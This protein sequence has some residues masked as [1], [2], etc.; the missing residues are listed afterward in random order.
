MMSKKDL[1][2]DT[3]MTFGEHLEVLRV[4]LWKAIVGLVIGTAL[5]FFVSRP[6]IIAIQV[7]VIKALDHHFGPGA[8]SKGAIEKGFIESAVDWY[9]SVTKKSLDDVKSEENA[10]EHGIADPRMKFSLNVRELAQ[11]LHEFSPKEYPAPAEDAHGATIEISIAHSPLAEYL[12]ENQRQ[13][14]NP[15]TDGVDEAFMVY[16]KVSMVIG[17]VISS[18]WVFYQ[19]WLFVGAGL[20]PHERKYVYTYLPVSLALFLIGAA[21]CFFAVIPFVL[22]F[23]FEFN[24]WLGIR[25]EIKISTWITFA[26]VVSLMFG[27]SFQLPLVM[28]F[29]ERIS[30]VNVKFYREKRRHAILVIAFLSMVLTPSDPVSMMMMMIPLCLLYELGIILCARKTGTAGNPFPPAVPA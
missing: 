23:L 5:G 11:S 14:M 2:D 25:P 28:L 18:P 4:H 13:N 21:F 1:F 22:K 20:Y 12:M 19:I 6:I 29:L 26:L 24:V 8:A 3:T 10:E 7:P 30:V 9:N 15:R 17:V 16:L 27:L